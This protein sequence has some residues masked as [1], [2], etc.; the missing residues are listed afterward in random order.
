MYRP[1]NGINMRHHVDAQITARTVK[2][3][4]KKEQKTSTI[5]REPLPMFI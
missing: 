1:D 5:V 3:I 4:S 2:V